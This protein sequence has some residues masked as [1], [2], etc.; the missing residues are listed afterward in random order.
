MIY[1]IKRITAAEIG[2]RQRFYPHSYRSRI[3]FSLQISLFIDRWTI[4]TV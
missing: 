4:H 2:S 3:N 1:S